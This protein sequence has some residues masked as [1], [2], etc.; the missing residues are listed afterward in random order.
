VAETDFPAALE[1]L[2]GMPPGRLRD[3]ALAEFLAGSSDPFSTYGLEPLDEARQAVL[4]TEYEAL[5]PGYAR[6][7]L[8]RRYAEVRAKE[9]PEAAV[10]WAR[11]LPDKELRASALRIISEN[12]PDDAGEARATQLHAEAWLLSDPGRTEELAAHFI[13]WHLAD[14]PA[15]DAWLRTVTSPDLRSILEPKLLEA[16]GAS[17]TVLSASAQRMEYAQKALAEEELVDGV[18]P[19]DGPGIPSE[20]RAALRLYSLGVEGVNDDAWAAAGTDDRRFLAEQAIQ[21]RLGDDLFPKMDNAREFFESLSP[22]ERSLGAWYEGGKVKIMESLTGASEW[23][24]ALPRGPGR[25]AAITAL[26]EYL[27]GA[28][29]AGRIELYRN[30][31]QPFPESAGSE[32]DAEAAFQWAADMSG[33]PER[34]RYTAMAARAWAEEDPAAAREAVSAANLPEAAKQALLR[35]LTEG[36]KP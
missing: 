16:P 35:Q 31:L 13:N 21:S 6:D 11:T 15:A 19:Y 25:D 33:E 1:G 9:D 23:M 7:T 5:P 22:E 10:T 17:L 2:K 36:G 27:T 4:R 14:P 29:E 26:V 28:A 18:R 32:H 8:A 12:L 30:V 34:V 20:W 3:E 24:A